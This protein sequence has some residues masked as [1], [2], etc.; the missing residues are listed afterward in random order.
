[1]INHFGFNHHLSMVI[2]ISHSLVLAIVQKNISR[3]HYQIVKELFPVWEAYYSKNSAFGVNTAFQ[4][5]G[6]F[7]IHRVRRCDCDACQPTQVI[8]S[9]FH[10]T[11]KWGS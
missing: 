11:Y 10:E 9:E 1:M 4:I 8:T 6:S 2:L 5:L 7:L 3:G